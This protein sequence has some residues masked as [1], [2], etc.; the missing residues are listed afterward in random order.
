MSDQIRTDGPNLGNPSFGEQPL[1]QKGFSQH[2]GKEKIANIQKQRLGKYIFQ[3][4]NNTR[5][6]HMPHTL[7]FRHTT[8]G[9]AM[10]FKRDAPF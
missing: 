1:E 2:W 7:E 10:R 6:L 3:V 8:D 5:E 4:G 9:T